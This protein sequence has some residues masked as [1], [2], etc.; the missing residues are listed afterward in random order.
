MAR[1]LLNATISFAAVHV[2]VALHSA[3]ESRTVHFHEVHLEDGARIEHRRFCAKEDKKVPYEEVVKGY[4]IAE[5]EY[6]VLSKDEV[7]AAAGE[8]TKLIDVEH[9]VPVADIDPVF[10]ARTYFLGASEGGE[11]AYRLFHDALQESGR[12]AIGR[13]TFH[14]REYLSAIRPLDGALALHTMHFADEIVRGG[15]LEA[16]DAGRAPAQREV[17]MASQL[18]DIM[19]E[20]FRPERFHD[21]FREAVLEVIRRKAEGE[22]VQEAPEEGPE[23]ASDLLAALQAS[24]K[25]SKPKGGA[26]TKAGGAKGKSRAKAKA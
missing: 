13:F 9:F 21:T 18:V 2:P 12:A 25:A 5:D 3:T 20:P 16:P 8:R 1:S 26:K 15:D 24:L 10:Y 4:E 6:V 11:D 22:E 23:P 7:K 19:H 14:N 17:E